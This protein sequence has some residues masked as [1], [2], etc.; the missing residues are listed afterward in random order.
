MD[1]YVFEKRF[2]LVDHCTHCHKIAL[3]KYYL[4]FFNLTAIACILLFA[5]CMGAFSMVH[6]VIF[7]AFLKCVAHCD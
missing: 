3:Q 7:G 5:N 6:F 2:M 1:F 4:L